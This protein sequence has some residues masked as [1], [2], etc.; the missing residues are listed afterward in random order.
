MPRKA[1]AKKKK[2]TKSAGYR[3]KTGSLSRGG[4][5][6]FAKMTI[7]QLRAYAKKN[8]VQLPKTAK[9]VELVSLLERWLPSPSVAS[10]PSVSQM[11]Q[12]RQYP[13]SSAWGQSPEPA[14]VQGPP[15][16]VAGIARSVPSGPKP[17]SVPFQPARVTMS[18]MQQN[19]AVVAIKV[20]V[21][22]PK[23]KQFITGLNTAAR[24][25]G[26]SDFIVNTDC[27]PNVGDVISMLGKKAAILQQC[28]KREVGGKETMDCTS[29]VLYAEVVNKGGGESWRGRLDMY[30]QLSAMPELA[31]HTLKVTSSWLCDS[32][33]FEF[34]VGGAWLGSMWASKMRG[35]DQTAFCVA[36]IPKGY[37]LWTLR[38]F[39][40][41]YT[42]P[43]RSSLLGLRTLYN[44]ASTSWSWHIVENRYE[45]SGMIELTKKMID[46]GIVPDEITPETYGVLVKIDSTAEGDNVYPVILPVPQKLTISPA[47]STPAGDGLLILLRTKIFDSVVSGFMVDGAASIYKPSRNIL[48]KIMWTVGSAVAIGGVAYSG[49]TLLSYMGYLSPLATGVSSATEAVAA[50]RMS[51]LANSARSV[52]EY[53]FVAY[54][55]V[56]NKALQSGTDVADAVNG[57]FGKLSSSVSA[58]VTNVA[59]AANV[60]FGKLSSNVSALG[61]DIAGAANVVSGKSSRSVPV[62]TANIGQWS[63]SVDIFK[64]PSSPIN[65]VAY[66]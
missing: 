66:K 52:N 22:Q 57:V 30:N 62:L 48:K 51:L 8:R 28:F 2:T 55:T 10:F 11:Q 37:Q 13:A 20:G 3:T 32:S 29:N 15:V 50:S 59:G 56:K 58:L 25:A 49:A 39:M 64:N 12:Q 16:T 5:E 27:A 9:K 44:L 19:P 60:V 1:A 46:A 47:T 17:T 41:S 7:A 6:M 36:E 63:G 31:K 21:I 33:D 35:A 4:P 23:G 54:D 34:S 26:S 61:T 45:E 14:P 24:G 38:N 65:L 42:D 43:S 18:R 40:R 53:L